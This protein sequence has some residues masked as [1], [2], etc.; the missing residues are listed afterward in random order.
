MG[1]WDG[2]VG[3]ADGRAGDSEYR[4]FSLDGL[5]VEWLCWVK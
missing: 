2:E 5:G 3:G 4:E 1:F